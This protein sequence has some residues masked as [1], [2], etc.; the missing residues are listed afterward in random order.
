MRLINLQANENFYRQKC[1][2]LSIICT[3]QL[4]LN[5][6][7]LSVL[8]TEKLLKTCSLKN[9]ETDLNSMSFIPLKIITFA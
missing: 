9:L 4:F 7:C 5:V 8:I 1:I 3:L 2:L 6:L